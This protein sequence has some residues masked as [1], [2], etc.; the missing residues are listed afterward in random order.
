MSD[1]ELGRRL[2]R[3][4]AAV[5]AL[6]AERDVLATLFRYSDA[7]DRRASNEWAEC[8]VA[9]GLLRIVDIDGGERRR[10]QG[11]DEIRA[12]GA[13]HTSEWPY[14]HGVAHPKVVLGNGRAVVR[15]GYTLIVGY[16]PQPT[17]AAWGNYEDVLVRELDGVWRFQERV[18]VAFQSHPQLPRSFADRL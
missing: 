16:F 8:F 9:D 11:R 17:L 18:I 3:I 5:V 13:S 12:F 15:S 1:T 10:Y 6:E 7:I 2:A 14:R 4:E